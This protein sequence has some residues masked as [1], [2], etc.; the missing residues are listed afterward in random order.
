MTALLEA[1]NDSP[2]PS[3]WRGTSGMHWGTT[4]PYLLH[5]Y[6]QKQQSAITHTCVGSVV[7][8]YQTPHPPS[9]P[10]PKPQP[11]HTAP[12]R[13]TTT[14]TALLLHPRGTK[15]LHTSIDPTLLKL[16]TPDP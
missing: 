14:M 13:T 7:S 3:A 15:T 8:P 2:A 9:P 11:R 4:N 12:S 6:I 1:I 16:Q 5:A 10:P